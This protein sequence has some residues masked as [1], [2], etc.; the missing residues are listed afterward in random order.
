[1]TPTEGIGLQEVVDTE[2][3]EPADEALDE[4]ADEPA[5]AEAATDSGSDSVET[6]RDW[7]HVVAFAVLPTVLI[8]L[9]LVA[10]V[11][12]WQTSS[13]DAAEVARIESVQ[14][15]KDT[16]VRMLSYN[17]ESVEEQLFSAR[18]LLTG[19]FQNSYT[20]LANST[21]IPGAREQNI[22]TVANVVAAASV[23]ATPDH[24]VVMV[25][26]NQTMIIGDDPPTDSASSVRVTLEKVDD[27]W[28]VSSFDPV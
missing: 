18:D 12:K 16:T 28:L 23:S 4:P 20:D 9:A 3:D 13:A 6:K 25:F 8:V 11:L 19:D 22:N 24:A 26:V 1:M 10:A 5:D 21:V 27:R 14:V 17:A 2:F 7:G 15:A